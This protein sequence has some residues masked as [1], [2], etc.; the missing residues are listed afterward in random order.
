LIEDAAFSCEVAQLIAFKVSRELAW[1]VGLDERG[2]LTW[3]DGD[4]QFRSEP[5]A[6]R[7]R[8]ALATIVGWL[9]LEPHL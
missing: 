1:R 2:A 9:P 3:S 7:G 4:E 8:R 6:S 5:L